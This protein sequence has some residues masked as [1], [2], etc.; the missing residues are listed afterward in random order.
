MAKL[1]GYWKLEA[2]DENWDEYMKAMGVN[3]AL[4]QVGKRVSSYEEIKE[5]DGEWTLDIT[6]TF[7]NAHLKFKLGEEFNEKTMDGRDVKSVFNVEDDKLV[8]Y[9]KSTAVGIP[10]SVITRERIDDDTM[11]IT[12]EAIG[13][14]IKTVRK[15]SKQVK[16]A[17]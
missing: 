8:H 3:F 15:F 4:R 17:S 5:V 11:T 12:L 10:D 13:K 7:K 6:S 16:A 14:N 1:L 2:S 9:Q